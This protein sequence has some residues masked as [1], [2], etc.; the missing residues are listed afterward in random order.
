MDAVKLLL[1]FF[2]GIGAGF[3]NVF[4][5]GGSF[6]T[7]PLLIFMGMPSAVAN[8]TNRLAVLAQCA[9]GV[10]R[11]RR[12]GIFNYKLGLLVAFPSV[13]GAVIGSFIAVNLPDHI[14]NKVLAAVMIF[15]LI[16]ILRKSPENNVSVKKEPNT[17]RKIILAAAFFFVGLYGGIIQAGVGI[18]IIAILSFMT[19]LS[20]VKI[21][22]LK[23]FIIAFYMI[24]SVAVFASGG[25]IEWAPG[26]VLAAGSVI[27]AW[28]G[29]NLAVKKGDRFIRAILAVV[30]PAIAVKLLFFM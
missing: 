17:R 18:V 28:L 12:K 20:L 16:S 1:I 11:F 23:L 10:E 8:G 22:S 13:T 30:I 4:A 29:V 25:K 24:F 26:L 2:A 5:G 15:V 14:F 19:D 27:G 9:L 7:I 6:L 21:N 3:I